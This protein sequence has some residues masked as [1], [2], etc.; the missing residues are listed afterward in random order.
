MPPAG[1]EP[2]IP[3]TKRPQTYALDLAA[4]EIVITKL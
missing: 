1:F 3:A 2:A 4:T